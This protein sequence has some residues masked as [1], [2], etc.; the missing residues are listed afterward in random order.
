MQAIVLNRKNFREFDQIISLFSYTAGKIEL[1]ARG[2]KKISSKNSALLEPGALVEITVVP[3]KEI[4]HLTKVQP[5]A[6]YVAARTHLPTARALAYVTKLTDQMTPAAHR[7]EAIFWLLKTWLDQIEKMAATEFTPGIVDAYVLKLLGILGWSPVLSGC[8][9]CARSVA[10]LTRVNMSIEFSASG[11]GLVCTECVQTQ[12]NTVLPV[13]TCTLS[14][15]S[16]LQLWQ[17]ADFAVSARDSLL[18]SADYTAAHELVHTFLE[19]AT[20]RAWPD[21]C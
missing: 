8:V 10:E 2:V 11:G 5:V 7:D 14:I 13:R 17:S 3:G 1:L 6:Y 12:K 18:W 21:W 15:L 9:F 4:D 20:E 16:L 19:Y